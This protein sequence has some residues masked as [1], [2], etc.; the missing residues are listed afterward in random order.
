MILALE[1]YS[2]KSCVKLPSLSTGSVYPSTPLVT[3]PNESTLTGLS[4]KIPSPSPS[5]KPASITSKQPSPS[6]SKSN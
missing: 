2:K 6:A 1:P 4:P 5:V 3:T